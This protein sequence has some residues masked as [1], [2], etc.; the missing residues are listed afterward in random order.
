MR[1]PSVNI[2]P[3]SIRFRLFRLVVVVATSA[4]AISLTVGALF[5]W[6]NKQEEVRRSLVTTADAV[7]IAASA[8]VA[9]YDAKSAKEAL[10]ILAA[11]QEIEAAAI[12]T[13]E[14]YR[15]ADFGG[16]AETPD[17]ANQLREHLP[18]FSLFTSSTSLFQQIRLDD[19]TIGYI[20]LRASLRDARIRFLLQ[21][22]IAIGVN[23]VGLMLVLGSGLRFLDKIV[24]PLKD[25]AATA[26]QIRQRGDFSLRA[27][28]RGSQDEID[29]LIAGFNAM[30]AEIET[31]EQALAAYRENLE[32]LVQV[33]T[34]ALDA[35]NRELKAAKEAAEA[36]TLSKSRFL[37]AASHD[38]RQPIQAINL[39][40][41][42]LVQSGLDETQRHI[43][44]RIGFALHALADLLDSLLDISRLD[45]GT[46]TPLPETITFAAAAER[47]N[48]EF[49]PLAMEKSLRF[50]IFLPQREMAIR[51]DAKLLRSLLGNLIGNAIKYTERGSVLIGMRRRGDHALI[52]VWDTGPGIAAEHQDAIFEEYFQLDNPE[53]NRSKGLGLGLAIARRIAKL[54]HTE[55]KCRS[56]LGKGSVFEFR[57]PLAQEDS[58]ADTTPATAAPPAD[59]PGS[60][61]I[62]VVEDD[63]NVAGALVV[64]LQALGKT[65][66]RYV[67]A[68]A[69]LADP[70]HRRACAY[71]TDFRL[72]GM[73][74][75]SFLN[76][77]QQAA[78]T[79]IRAVVLTG[80]TTPDQAEQAGAC[81]WPR[82]LKPVN[83]PCLLNALAASAGPRQ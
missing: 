33:R 27:A 43:S 44:D 8:A 51:T 79:P 68:E 3:H 65:V 72:P 74:G 26:N 40:H 4:L 39:F 25:L 21:A 81:P 60:H 55:V 32:R 66:T 64:S 49:S 19:S 70:D 36:A 28:P 75:I 77:V 69:A 20:Y 45:T 15:L 42:A 34:E 61:H 5:E 10:G 41:S 12:F 71:I 31:R 1:R 57:L 47:I 62:V 67:S 73:D 56:R 63:D 58:D 76:A 37:A 59:A 30:L 13:L 11:R 38:L 18:S 46:V 6:S 14:G 16:N 7:S 50:R 80:D 48:A 52:Q 17:S 82:L 35:T 2:D 9:F 22:A 78:A 54:L 24:T 29:D 53:R 23:L 83:L